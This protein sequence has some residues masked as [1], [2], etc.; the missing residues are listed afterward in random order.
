MSNF[1]S[2]FKR[3]SPRRSDFLNVDPNKLIPIS[4]LTSQDNFEDLPVLYLFVSFFITA[5]FLLQRLF[6]CIKASSAINLAHESI[7]LFVLQSNKL[8]TC[9]LE[10]QT[11][12]T[13]FLPD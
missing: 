2:Y 12:H 6:Y 9:T 8:G 7:D 3:I 13:W 10:W 4:S 5:S 1:S 11:C